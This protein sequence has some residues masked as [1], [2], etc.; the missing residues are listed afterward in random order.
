ML[1]RWLSRVPGN[2]LQTCIL[3]SHP[4]AI[5]PGLKVCASGGMGG[6]PYKISEGFLGET[7]GAGCMVLRSERIEEGRVFGAW[8]VLS[9]AWT[10]LVPAGRLRRTEGGDLVGGIGDMRGLVGQ[11]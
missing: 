2:M 10:S 11:I 5:T 1:Y 8:E 4:A 3:A 9:G 7:G 6:T